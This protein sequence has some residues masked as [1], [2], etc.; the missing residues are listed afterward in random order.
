MRALYDSG[1]GSRWVLVDVEGLM[2]VTIVAIAGC[3]AWPAGAE[4]NFGDITQKASPDGCISSINTGGTCVD[5]ADVSDTV[6]IAVSPDGNTA[7]VASQT[8]G[9]AVIVFD[10]AA[11]G[12]LTRKPGVD[13]CISDDG[14]GTACVD[15]RGLADVNDVTVSPDGKT[16]YVVGGDTSAGAV[17]VFDR[18]ADGT[19]DQLPGPAGCISEDGSDGCFDGAA[20]EVASSVA[21][22]PDGKSVYV[23]AAT[24]HAVVLVQTVRPTA[25]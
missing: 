19:L 20:L 6:A 21:V 22:S 1:R 15:G 17:A 18:A 8:G 14:T 23:T 2:A 4:A 7:Y 13:G 16:V 11:N 10:R 25:A 9:G 5:V 12:T 3:L 24:S